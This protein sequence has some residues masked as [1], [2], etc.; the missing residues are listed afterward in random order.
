MYVAQFVH[1]HVLVKSMKRKNRLISCAV[2][3]P[4]EEERRRTSYERGR[5]E[6]IVEK[7]SPE[8]QGAPGGAV[9]VPLS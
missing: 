8:K 5:G 9:Q 2:V 1:N 6:K 7:C 4:T 3:K